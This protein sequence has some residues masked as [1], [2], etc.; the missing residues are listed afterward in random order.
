MLI[1][2]D[3]QI[4]PNRLTALSLQN[5][6]RFYRNL[7]RPTE[8]GLFRQVVERLRPAFEFL[9]G[10]LEQGLLVDLFDPLEA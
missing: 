1:E 2:R 10:R 8:W 9:E 4:L 7:D 3:L 5:Y 6:S